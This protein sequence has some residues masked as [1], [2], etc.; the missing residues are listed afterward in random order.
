MK[1]MAPLVV[2]LAVAAC[3]AGGSSSMPAT[4]APVSQNRVVPQWEATHAAQRVC[5]DLGRGYATCDALVLSEKNS[6]IGPAVPGWQPANFQA[7]YNLPSSTNGK[8]QIVA[9]VDAYDNPNAASDLSTYRTEFSLGTANFT[10]YNQT[11]QTSN[12]PTGN[13][14][15]G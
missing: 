11:G 9:I 2:A 3:N 14:N 12:Y 6:K 4:G 10:K 1:L 13:K 7:V 15:W 5:P 8:G